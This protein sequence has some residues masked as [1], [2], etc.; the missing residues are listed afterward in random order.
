MRRA[1]YPFLAALLLA[2]PALG[3][4]P[5]QPRFAQPA[6]LPQ[7]TVTAPLPP[8]PVAPA[9]PAEEQLVSF[10]PH[11]TE[12][13]W[14]NNN[15]ELYASDP[16][17]LRSFMLKDFGRRQIDAAEALR[18]IRS[19]RLTQHGTVGSPQ[20][21]MEYWLCDGN[22]PQAQ[23]QGGHLLAIDQASLRAEQ[24]QGQWCVR[25]ASRVLFTFGVQQAEARQAV[26][27]LQRHGFTQIGYVGWPVPVMIYFL[28]GG[29]GT[30][31]ATPPAAGTAQAARPSPLQGPLLAGSVR[32]LAP[33]RMSLANFVRFSPYQVEVRQDKEVWKLTYGQHTLARFATA[34]EARQALT[35]VQAYH[36]TEEYLIGTPTP[37]FAYFLAHGQAP[38][39][40]PRS[41]IPCQTFRPEAVTVKQ[42]GTSWMLCEGDRPLVSF[43]DH[44]EDAQ[45]L[46]R[47]IQRFRFD[48][49]CRI[50]P[51]GP[52]SMPFLVK[53]H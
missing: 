40:L 16:Q 33:P 47:V 43:D 3:Q 51:V 39:G 35:V 26:A 28:G 37:T 5:G 17:H 41:G 24:I 38:R 30:A 36:F 50:G 23:G 20:P 42:A 11:T 29:P 12:L 2:G 21:I 34:P 53:S 14:V 49:L 19:L 1:A 9:G 13:R 10:D 15:W 45:E 52:L 7:S 44:K 32:Q 6:L 8:V 25:D 31:P 27:I 22:S 46:A 4:A 48:T 18:L